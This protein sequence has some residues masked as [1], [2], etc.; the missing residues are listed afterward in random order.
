LDSALNRQESFLKE[1]DDRLKLAE[2]SYTVIVDGL[3][4][5]V[6]KAP[7]QSDVIYSML[8]QL[9]VVLDAGQEVVDGNRQLVE[10][11]RSRQ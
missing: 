3:M 6:E 8:T 10:E 2:Q 1:H 4:A 11:E 9:R 7:D 5:L